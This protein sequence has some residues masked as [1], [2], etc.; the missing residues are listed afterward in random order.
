[1]ATVAFSV[2]SSPGATRVSA[3]GRPSPRA[4]SGSCGRDTMPSIS[5][6]PMP[7]SPIGRPLSSRSRSVESAT[8]RR[9]TA[10]RRDRTTDLRRRQR[11]RDVA[12]ATRRDAARDRAPRAAIARVAV[13]R[14]GET[15][16]HEL[17]IGFAARSLRI[18]IRWLRSVSS[19]RT[20]PARTAARP[21]RRSPAAAQGDSLL[22]DHHPRHLATRVDEQRQETA[23][24][25][26]QVLGGAAAPGREATGARRAVEFRQSTPRRFLSFLVWRSP[27]LRGTA[28][29]TATFCISSKSTRSGTFPNQK[30]AHIDIPGS[31]ARLYRTR[32]AK[33]GC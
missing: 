23:L 33:H 26:L 1:M 3:V 13:G 20:V 29:G 2:T 10:L 15:R 22:L 14:K 24:R 30:L 17:A 5:T 9:D 11:V 7:R 32:T 8:K 21:G 25:G 16:Q 18:A 19:L 27:S 28:Y 6:A 12:V 4:R 31:S